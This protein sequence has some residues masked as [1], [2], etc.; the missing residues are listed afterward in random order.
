MIPKLLSVKLFFY[1]RLFV[2]FSSIFYVLSVRSVL[3][4]FWCSDELPTVLGVW[5]LF[6]ELEFVITL[7][8]VLG[9]WTFDGFWII[10][11]L[12]F[13]MVTYS[14]IKSSLLNIGIWSVLKVLLIITHI[15]A[16][17]LVFSPLKMDGHTFMLLSFF[18]LDRL[19]KCF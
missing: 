14:V 10:F 8:I 17:V 6:M 7:K 4:S 15:L 12:L 3:G 19:L 2:R 13:E 16:W 1:F 5:V 18:S 9:S 11:T